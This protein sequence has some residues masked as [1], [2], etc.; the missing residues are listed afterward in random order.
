MGWAEATIEPIRSIRHGG[1][2]WLAIAG[3]AFGGSCR[4]QRDGVETHLLADGYVGSVMIVFDDPDGDW[5]NPAEELTYR[6]PP[7]G[8]LHI[9]DHRPNRLQARYFYVLRGGARRQLF[10][11]T[12][13]GVGIFDWSVGT[14][15]MSRRGQYLTLPY[16]RYVVGSPTYPEVDEYNG[17]LDYISRSPGRR[18][19]W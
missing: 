16:E 19:P 11:L 3:I 12:V 18:G 6:I 17:I 8:V 7:D 1:V 2:A 9:R 4:A 5:I 14:T 13:R 15:T 10:P